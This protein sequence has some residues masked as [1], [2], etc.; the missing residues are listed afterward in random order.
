M[1]PDVLHGIQFGRISREVFRLQAAF[2]V[3]DELLRDF[4]TVAREPIPNQQDVAINVAEQMF[5][6][7]DDLLGLD[8]LFEHLK[9]EIPERD[10]GD[11][12]QGLPVEVELEY[13][14]LPSR[15]P[16]APPVRPLAK[17]TLVYEDDRP[18][19]FL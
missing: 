11:H 19:L 17:A 4:A 9:V 8:G 12:R 2:L 18:A 1:C 14:R 6:E 13:G 7:F 10:A 5:E 16:G 3:S 15:R